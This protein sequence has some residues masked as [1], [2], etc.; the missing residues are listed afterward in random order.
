MYYIKKNLKIGHMSGL[1]LEN[2]RNEEFAIARVLIQTN[3]IIAFDPFDP[4]MCIE[5]KIYTTCQ[6]IGT[7]RCHHLVKYAAK[8]EYEK[9]WLSTVG[10]CVLDSGYLFNNRKSEVT[11]NFKR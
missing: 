11:G 1:K 3:G 2:V 8:H 10:N 7:K 9:C 4:I 5:A 6:V